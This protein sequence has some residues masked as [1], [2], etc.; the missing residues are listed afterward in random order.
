MP[1]AVE[2]ILLFGIRGVSQSKVLCE[3][4]PVLRVV[5]RAIV[6]CLVVVLLSL[7]PTLLEELVF[8]VLHY[9]VVIAY[10]SMPMPKFG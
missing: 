10:L 8:P 3:L 2:L 4:I 9:Y 1:P 7:S 6:P 5:V